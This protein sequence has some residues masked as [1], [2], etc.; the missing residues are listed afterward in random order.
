MKTI[1][2]HCLKPFFG[3]AIAALLLISYSCSPEGN[4]SEFGDGPELNAVDAKA[5]N[6]KKVKRPWKIRSAGTFAFDPSLASECGTAQPPFRIEGSGEASLVGRYAVEI[7][8]CAPLS[9][10]QFINGTLTAANG[11]E[12]YFISTLFT[13][14]EGKVEYMVTGGTGRFHGVTGEFTLFDVEPLVFE[15]GPGEPPRGTYA[16]AGEGYLEY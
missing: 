8:W 16:N 12:I 7:T 15:N 11:D 10:I 6:G 3:M 9:P 4:S 13:P 2:L 1:K 5:D 14:E